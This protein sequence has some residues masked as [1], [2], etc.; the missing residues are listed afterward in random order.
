MPPGFIQEDQFQSAQNIN[1]RKKMALGLSFDEEDD[2]FSF[3]SQLKPQAQ[4]SKY[5]KEGNPY[6]EKKGSNLPYFFNKQL[7][8]KP[9]SNP[10]IAEKKHSVSFFEP[11]KPPDKSDENYLAKYLLRKPEL[12][13]PKLENIAEEKEKR[14]KTNENSFSNH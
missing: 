14:E 7:P 8:N 12:K 4:S 10:Q 3:P 1:R 5:L 2:S 9:P 6:S 13:E 11:S